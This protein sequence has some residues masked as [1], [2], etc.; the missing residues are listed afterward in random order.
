MTTYANR[1]RLHREDVLENQD[2]VLESFQR[3][4]GP[5]LEMFPNT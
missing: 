2:A 4:E 5:D 3:L 1:L